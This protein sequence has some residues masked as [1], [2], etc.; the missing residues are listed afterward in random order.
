MMPRIIFVFMA[1]L[2]L[3]AA[4]VHSQLTLTGQKGL[5]HTHSAQTLGRG[6][7]GINAG[8]YYGLDNDYIEKAIEI[9]NGQAV[10][11]SGMNPTYLST[12]YNLSYGLLNWWDLS[13]GIPYYKDNTGIENGSDAGMGDFIFSMKMQYPPYEHSHVFDMTYFGQLMIPTAKKNTGLFP[14]QPYYTKAQNVKPNSDYF[15]DSLMGDLDFGALNSDTLST[16][17]KNAFDSAVNGNRI[18]VEDFYYGSGYPAF[19]LKMLW[20]F[21]ASEI[22]PD[23]NIKWHFNFGALFNGK[24][25]RDNI[26]VLGSALEWTPHPVVTVFTDFDGQA[27]FS[28]LAAGFDLGKEPLVLA[29]GVGFNIPGGAH[30]LIAFEKCFSYLDKFK[31]I[32][33]N[34][35][36]NQAYQTKI[37]P[38]SGISVSLSWNGSVLGSDS[39]NDGIP[40][41]IDNCPNDPEDVDGFEDTDGC[42]DPDNDRD[43]ILDIRDKCPSKAEDF[44]NHLDDDGCPDTDNDKDAIIDTKDKCP[45]EP[46]DRDGFEDLDGCPDPDNDR[47]NI[48]DNVDKCP[49][50][51]EDIDGFEDADGCPDLD[52]DQDGILDA[53]DKC[54]LQK[55]NINGFQDDDGCPDIKAKEI[56]SRV[57]LEGVN[58]KTNSTELTFESGAVLDKVVESMTAFPDVCIEIRGFTDN[59]GQRVKN[60]ELSQGRAESVKAYLMSKSVDPRR[61]ATIGRGQEDPIASNNKAD[62]RAK[63]RRIEMYRVKCAQ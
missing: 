27:R 57:V 16:A 39:D 47:D 3:L 50:D 32:Y 1:L 10:F 26:F 38:A 17:L 21:D 4:N 37:Y 43:G 35:D 19:L 23:V 9:Q 13:F 2:A 25:G 61:I 45:N 52:N 55:E 40:D 36:K 30:I 42:P 6:V 34:A 15:I 62:G 41:K 63:N 58:F 53:K 59:V 7:L 46:E 60:K 18:P 51:P 54:P 24:K 11:A 5:M 12:Y 33:Y 56:E 28:Q 29:S 22:N 31:Q 20:T 14:R 44:D 49:N 48:P 8:A